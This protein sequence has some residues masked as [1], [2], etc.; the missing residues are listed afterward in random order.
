MIREFHETRNLIRVKRMVCLSKGHF[1]YL[2]RYDR[3][4]VKE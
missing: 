4:I 2:F 1:G 3:K